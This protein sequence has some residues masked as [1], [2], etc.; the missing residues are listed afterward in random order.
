MATP[1]RGIVY[2]KQDVVLIRWNH[3]AAK[4]GFVRS[5]L[6]RLVIKRYIHNE[7]PVIIGK[8]CINPKIEHEMLQLA[9]VKYNLVRSEDPEINEWFKEMA[10]KKVRVA[11]LVKELMKRSIVL[12]GTLEEEW[13]PSY[14]DIE[15]M[16]NNIQLPSSY[17][18][19]YLEDIKPQMNVG[20]KPARKEE[21]A[22]VEV[23]QVGELLKEEGISIEPIK[24]IKAEGRIDIGKKKTIVSGKACKY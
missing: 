16:N 19:S 1:Y 22:K 8:V 21:T 11:A 7:P 3:L 23:K 10:R 6:V 4:Q 13:I 15:V 12:V 5:G 18:T 17:A 9:P 14:F 24:P 2:G 20:W